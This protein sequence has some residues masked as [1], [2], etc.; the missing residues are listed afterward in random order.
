MAKACP[1]PVK[2]SMAVPAWGSATEH[3]PLWERYAEHAKPESGLP[4]FLVAFESWRA[5]AY[6]QAQVLDAMW[7]KLDP[8]GEHARSFYELLSSYKE[9]LKLLL[10]EFNALYVAAATTLPCDPVVRRWVDIVRALESRSPRKIK[11]PVKH[12]AKPSLSLKAQSP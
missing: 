12:S 10:N 11:R 7:P 8:S 9:N 6:A 4:A 3:M 1:S 5:T 2:Q